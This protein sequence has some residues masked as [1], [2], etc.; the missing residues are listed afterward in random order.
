MPTLVAGSIATDHLMHF[1]GKFADQLLADQLHK[2]SLSFLVD[3]LDV[4]NGGVAANISYG[5]AQLGGSPVMVGNVGEDF[6]P[7][8]DF[9]TGAGVDCRHV[10]V[11]KDAMPRSARRKEARLRRDAGLI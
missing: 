4:K 3:A 8:R 6:G 1:P 2:V 9:L 5:M 11:S 7:Y 10:L